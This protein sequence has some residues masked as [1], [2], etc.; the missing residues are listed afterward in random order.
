MDTDNGIENPTENNEIFVSSERAI[1][2]VKGSAS[3][4]SADRVLKKFRLDYL[5]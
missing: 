2:R 4:T 5:Q 3:L 1:R